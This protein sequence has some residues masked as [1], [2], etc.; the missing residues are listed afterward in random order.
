LPS[1]EPARRFPL[2][3]A[4]ILLVAVLCLAFQLRLPALLPAEDDYKAVQAVLEAEAQPGDAV[5]LFPWWTE[6]ARLFSPDRV[7]VVGYQGS[8]S[9]PLELHH[10]VWVL[11]QPDLPKASW[12]SFWSAFGDRRTAVGAE[13]AFGRLKLQ[14]YQNGRARP[15]R[16][17]F[18]EALAQAQ[19]Y[20]E[21]PDGQRL[22]CQWDGRAHRCGGGNY[23]AVEW[24]EIRFQPRRCLRLF[25]PGGPAKLVVELQNVA[26]AE[27]LQ[28]MGGFIWDR[29]RFHEDRLTEAHLKADVNGTQLAAIDFPIG[30]VGLQRAEGGAVPAG[31]TVRISTQSQNA[32][33]RDL[34]VEAYGIGGAP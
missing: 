14:L 3:G 12:P 33:L 22:P 15:V 32:E 34:C 25:P 9:D 8:D 23:V 16:F 20:V 5:L 19:V 7:T 2:E 29:G 28:L 24:H 1:P 11:S 21:G 18:T 4:A 10:R 17:S 26:G 30:R 27:A 13:R 31:A 6:R